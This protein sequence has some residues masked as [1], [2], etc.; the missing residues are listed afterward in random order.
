M[1]RD[2]RVPPGLLP[3]VAFEF[4]ARDSAMP[5]NRDP[6]G[7]SVRRSRNI[8]EPCWGVRYRMYIPR[9][10]N[11]RSGKIALCRESINQPAGSTASHTITLS[12]PPNILTTSFTTMAPRSDFLSG[13]ATT[14]EFKPRMGLWAPLDTWAYSNPSSFAKASSSSCDDSCS[15]S[16]SCSSPSSRRKV[17]FSQGSACTQT[18]EHI[19]VSEYSASE[20]E[21]CWYRRAEY[22]AMRQHNQTI[23]EKLVQN[24][25]L[26]LETESY[27]G[28]ERQF[29]MEKMRSHQMMHSAK[30]AVLEE[31]EEQLRFDSC[32]H[33]DLIAA[34]YSCYTQESSYQARHRGHL[35]SLEV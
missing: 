31:Q 35:Q 28:L 33:Y 15:S 5:V 27:F 22:K 6:V 14:F 29:H 24:I 9:C 11:N 32:V 16:S 17:R 2:F 34:R 21:A 19:H 1:V 20:K 25:P 18:Q 4:P 12:F 13:S 7:V 30:W 3:H 8:V 10:K 26:H 23:V